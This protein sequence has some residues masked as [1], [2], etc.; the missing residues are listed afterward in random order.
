MIRKKYHHNDYIVVFGDIIYCQGQC[1]SNEVG[2]N[3]FIDCGNTTINPLINPLWNIMFTA[4]EISENKTLYPNEDREF[5][6]DFQKIDHMKAVGC[7]TKNIDT[8]NHLLK[9]GNTPTKRLI[10]HYNPNLPTDIQLKLARDDNKEIRSDLACNINLCAEAMLVLVKDDYELTRSN[11]AR[12]RRNNAIP[13]NLIE[14]LATDE[15]NIKR[16]LYYKNT[17]PQYIL[18]YLHC[19]NSFKNYDKSHF[20]PTLLKILKREQALFGFNHRP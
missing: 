11:L 14:L 10:A 8:I 15:A 3:P 1:W 18:E 5:I 17:T 13:D 19:N 9:I 12:I 2:A 6:T 4:D 7:G 16:I 20:S